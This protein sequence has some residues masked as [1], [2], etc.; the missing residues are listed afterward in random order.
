MLY[1][2]SY[3]QY[4]PKLRGETLDDPQHPPDYTL[5]RLISKVNDLKQC[6]RFRGADPT[7]IRK[8]IERTSRN[9]ASYGIE[10]S[11]GELIENAPRLVLDK[12]S[13]CGLRIEVRI[14][15][16]RIHNDGAH[17]FNS[18]SFSSGKS[19]VRTLEFNPDLLVRKR[20]LAGVQ[21]ENTEGRIHVPFSFAAAPEVPAL[22]HC[23]ITHELDHVK[24]M[25]SGISHSSERCLFSITPLS[26][27]PSIA[28]NIYLEGGFRF[29]ELTCYE[30][31]IRD[32]LNEGDPHDR[33]GV[34]VGVLAELSLHTSIFLDDLVRQCEAEMVAPYIF[35]TADNELAA[36]CLFSSR[37]LDRDGSLVPCVVQLYVPLGQQEGEIEPEKLLHE[38]LLRMLE[39]SKDVFLRNRSNCAEDVNVAQILDTALKDREPLDPILVRLVRNIGFAT[40]SLTFDS[41]ELED[42]YAEMMGRGSWGVK[43]YL[44]VQMNKLEKDS[45]LSSSAQDM[46]DINSSPEAFLLACEWGLSLGA[47]TKK[48]LKVIKKMRKKHPALWKIRELEAKLELHHGNLYQAGLKIEKALQIASKETLIGVVPYQAL[49]L[50]L[51]TFHDYLRC[52]GRMDA[53]K[54]LEHK[55]SE[56]QDLIQYASGHRW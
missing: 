53:A 10:H 30:N 1:M 52:I 29:D 45:L 25:D 13:P 33:V 55:M 20:A 39:R 50:L 11:K 46:I 22:S 38:S 54:D 3:S 9:W 34:D 24:T 56:A 47:D 12:S 49:A 28:S 7:L 5:L 16:L 37:Q 35:R 17:D 44:F 40:N 51:D 42:D 4:L 41:Q 2:G 8:I 14:P 21:F 6:G 26:S 19:R 27:D 31:G 36:K 15:V 18:F 43:S 32:A 48:V 23:G